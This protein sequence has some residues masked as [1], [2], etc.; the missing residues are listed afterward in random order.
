MIKGHQAI[1]MPKAALSAAINMLIVQMKRLFLWHETMVEI[2][3][4]FKL[5]ESELKHWRLYPSDSF[6]LNEKDQ[7]CISLGTYCLLETSPGRSKFIRR[8]FHILTRPSELP[9]LPLAERH[10][11][12]TVFMSP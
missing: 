8:L 3:A 10:C 1:S 9:I 11:F 12:G 7:F 2:Y 5:I 6:N 4:I